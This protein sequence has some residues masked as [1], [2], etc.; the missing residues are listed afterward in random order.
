MIIQL[1]QLKMTFCFFQHLIPNP[2]HIDHCPEFT[3]LLVEQLG[4]HALTTY[5]AN[6]SPPPF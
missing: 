2:S 5:K 4:A 6:E 1:Y 3:S